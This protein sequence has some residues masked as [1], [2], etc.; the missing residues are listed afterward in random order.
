MR[1]AC[2]NRSSL[3]VVQGRFK[4]IARLSTRS[5]NALF[6]LDLGG[7]LVV[8]VEV[9]TANK[10]YAIWHVFSD[11]SFYLHLL[12]V[13]A[14]LWMFSRMGKTA[15]SMPTMA[16]RFGLVIYWASITIAVAIVCV[17]IVIVTE[18]RSPNEFTWL[19]CAGLLL[20]AV[21]A[22]LLGKA[23]RYILAGPSP[24]PDS[25][26]GQAA[27]T[28]RISDHAR[29]QAPHRTSV[30]LSRPHNDARHGPWERH[31][32]PGAHWD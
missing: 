21:V 14:I 15:R 19:V 5:A 12:V 25:D 20:A 13:L 18:A 26:K 32:T 24:L 23:I 16:A 9:T 29:S 11:P 1:Q 22:W 30:P 28:R 31:P 27:G 17:A 8:E 3:L 10:L 7:G 4:P 2:R 6:E